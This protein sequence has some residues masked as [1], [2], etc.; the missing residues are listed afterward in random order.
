MKKLSIL[1]VA[2]IWLCTDQ[3]LAQYI[4]ST[5]EQPLNLTSSEVFYVNWKDV[6]KIPSHLPYGGIQAEILEPGGYVTLKVVVLS[7][8]STNEER[9]LWF[10]ETP[11]SPTDALTVDPLTIS[12]SN[13]IYSVRN[14]HFNTTPGISEPGYI[15][16]PAIFEMDHNHNRRYGTDIK[17]GMEEASWAISWGFRSRLKVQIMLKV[18]KARVTGLN[19]P[20]WSVDYEGD[21]NR[22]ELFYKYYDHWDNYWW[23]LF[24]EHVTFDSPHNMYYPI[25]DE[26]IADEVG[27]YISNATGFVGVGID[28]SSGALPYEFVVDGAIVSDE[29]VIKNIEPADYVFRDDYPLLTLEEVD[30]FIEQNHHLP[31]VPN[32]KD[33]IENDIGLGELNMKMLEKVEELTLYTIQQQKMIEELRFRI[34]EIKNQKSK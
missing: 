30:K 7:T 31:N 24:E 27:L 11:G 1:L 20:G 22:E 14:P 9:Y 2:A 8:G 19:I 32:Q 23:E 29:M 4:E 17:K 3:L 13:I 25:A 6:D 10:S 5:S 33:A 16:E 21:V 18:Y 34:Q 12:R 15:E 28:E 26:Y